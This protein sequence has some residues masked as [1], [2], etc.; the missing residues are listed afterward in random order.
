MTGDFPSL[1]SAILHI[2]YTKAQGPKINLHSMLLHV[3]QRTA[4]ESTLQY[5]LHMIGS[6]VLSP[7]KRGEVVLLSSVQRP[8]R[9][10]MRITHHSRRGL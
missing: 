4:M 3:E 5:V 8:T 7:L 6:V 1:C 9:N 2:S 10:G